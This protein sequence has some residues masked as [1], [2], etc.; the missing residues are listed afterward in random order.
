M[1]YS[2]EEQDDAFDF[3]DDVLD[4]IASDE[5]VNPDDSKRYE[6]LADPVPLPQCLNVSEAARQDFL[7]A[8]SKDSKKRTS[9]AHTD[10][11]K[12][13][14]YVLKGVTEEQLETAMDKVVFGSTIS[15]EAT[16]LGVSPNHLARAINSRYRLRRLRA[17]QKDVDYDLIRVERLLN[18]AYVELE[19]DPSPKWAK[20]V[21]DVL[22]YRAR[23]LGL[24]KG[25]FTR[26][27]VRIAST[28]AE[29]IC[30]EIIKDKL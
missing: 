16:I 20:V 19:K 27:T 8:L 29:A 24:E 17:W 26:E 6:T 30:M 14:L 3:E 12:D 18:I 9:V 21:L 15:K 2:K 23:V 13:G 4:V 5:L 11:Q 10:P 1:D 7:A 25:E 22:A 28:G